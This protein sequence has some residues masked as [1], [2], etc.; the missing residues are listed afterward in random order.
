MKS[1]AQA[2]V[3]TA[4]FIELSGEDVLDPDAS[5]QALEYIVFSLGEASEEEKK[6]LIGYCREKAA[7]IA[8]QPAPRDEERREFYLR[9]EED[10]GL[11]EE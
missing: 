4:A 8:A 3:E 7:A 10:F 2:L 11:S 5:V 1:L 9:F 6:A